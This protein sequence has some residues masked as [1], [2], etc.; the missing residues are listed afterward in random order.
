MQDFFKTKKAA[1]QP[2]GA[3]QPNF[4][5]PLL[6]LQLKGNTGGNT[7]AAIALERPA[8]TASNA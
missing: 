5:N 6:Q 4:Y 3:G 7:V 2:A 1:A 8:N